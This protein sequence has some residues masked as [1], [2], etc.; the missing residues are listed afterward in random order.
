MKRFS[1]LLLALLGWF[2][3]GWTQ[4][5]SYSLN[6]RPYHILD[7][8]EIK[9]G[10]QPN[11][12]SSLKYYLRGDVVRYALQLD[13]SSQVV[14][15]KGDRADLRY[16]F[17]DNNEWLVQSEYPT[18]IGGEREPVYQKVLVDSL[19]GSYK[20]V[21][22]PR[23]EGDRASA[24]YY[25]TKKP[26]FN[27]FYKTP[28]NLFEIDEPFFH[29]RANPILYLWGGQAQNDENFL[30]FNQRGLEIRGGVD[31]RIFFYTNIQETQARFADYVNQRVDSTLA[32]PGAALYKPYRSSIFEFTDGYDL[33]GVDR[34]FIYYADISLR[35]SCS[36]IESGPY[37]STVRR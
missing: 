33:R 2:Q 13:T 21:E 29:L 19:N 14:L 10:I 15:S 25:Q 36:G 4:G 11:Y 8:L 16:L 9:S 5:S 23:E 30:L 35:L 22:V 31:E 3:M 24:Y 1:V 34:F 20:M 12:H 37:K 27:T 7:R 28:A 32:V 18:T 26:I 17:K 6:Q